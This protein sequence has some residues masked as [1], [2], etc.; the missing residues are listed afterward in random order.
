MAIVRHIFG[1]EIEIYF[2]VFPRNTTKL[3][4]ML[5]F[6][7]K[8]LKDRQTLITLLAWTEIF[9]PFFGIRR[10][11]Y[12]ILFGWIRN[13]NQNLSK[14]FFPSCVFP[15]YNSRMVQRFLSPMWIENSIYQ[16]VVISHYMADCIH[17]IPFPLLEQLESC[18]YE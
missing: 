8:D 13:K 17:G 4:S 16:P 18:G 5:Q 2:E 9:Q 3:L 7:S 15:L 12:P 14:S 1:T 11:P 10:C 6:L